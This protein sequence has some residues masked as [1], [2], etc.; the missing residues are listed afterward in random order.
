MVEQETIVIVVKFLRFAHQAAKDIEREPGHQLRCALRAFEDLRDQ[1]NDV[2]SLHLARQYFHDAEYE[3]E[4]YFKALSLLGSALCL[5]AVGNSEP[6]SRRIHELLALEPKRNKVAVLQ[7]IALA[8]GI[9][10]PIYG[11][12]IP[13]ALVRGYRTSEWFALLRLQNL[14]KES[15]SDPKE[16]AQLLVTADLSAL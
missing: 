12:E 5:Y 14:V 15:G 6:A 10:L 13:Q 1:P 7:G 2:Q 9:P 8:C 16:L 4:G 3:E 11:S